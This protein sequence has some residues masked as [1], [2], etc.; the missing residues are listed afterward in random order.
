MSESAFAAIKELASQNQFLSGG[1]LLMAGGFLMNW[2]R[3]IPVAVKAAALRRFTTTV[4]VSSRDPAFWW[5]Q[6]WLA[7]QSFAK[8]SGALSASSKHDDD[9]GPQLCNPGSEGPPRPRILFT[10]APGGHWLKYENRWLHVYRDRKEPGGG[11]VERFDMFQE[12]LTLRLYSRD[13]SIAR[14]LFEEARDHALPPEDKRATVFGVSYSDW[15]QVARSVL[16]EHPTVVLAEGIMEDVLADVD[17]FRKSEA[18]YRDRGLPYHRGYL[19]H[20][21]PG[22]GKTSLIASVAAHL[23]FNV[24]V[25]SLGN[26][27]LDESKLRR[28]F[29]QLPSRTILVIED[30]DRDLS[31]ASNDGQVETHNN[32]LTFSAILNLLDGI[33]TPEGRIL[34]MTTNHRDRLD[35]AMI[36]PGRVDREYELRNASED[37]ARRLFL[38][39]FPGCDDRA[40]EFSAIVGDQEVSMASIQGHLLKHRDNSEKAA[41]AAWE[42]VC[43]NAEARS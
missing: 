18:W 37:Q 31:A 42:L 11:K 13:R 39:F 8:R 3:K 6:K 22:N 5:V 17:E 24:A 20:G 4:D 33:G 26:D 32:K 29:S 28:L 27:Q 41:Q 30:V 10:P 15:Q 23:R 21:E 19:L 35:P 7:D 43:E 40:V 9:S 14:R 36:R 1:F 34:F 25:L 12:T 16:R 2:A 38:R